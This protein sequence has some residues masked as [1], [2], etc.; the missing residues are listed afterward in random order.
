[1]TALAAVATFTQHQTHQGD[2][3]NQ[4]RRNGKHREKG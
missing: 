3:H 4:Y 2:H 1:M